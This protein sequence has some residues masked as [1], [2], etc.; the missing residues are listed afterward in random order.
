MKLREKPVFYGS[1]AVIYFIAYVFLI[2]ISSCVTQHNLE[3]MQDKNK[4]IKT[5]SE[6]Q[7]AD[8]RLKPN[9]EL[10]I[11]ISSLDEAAANVFTGT[12]T[13]QAYYM[14][15]ISPYG[16]SLISY[17]ID[18][19]GYLL[20]PYIGRLLVK[21]K[22]TAE[23]IESIKESLKNILSQ[24]VVSVKL[25]N[26][27]VSVLGEVRSPGHFA[28]AQDKLTI[29]DAISLAGDITVF[30]NREEVILT[31]NEDGKNIRINVNLNRSD[32]LSSEYYNLRPNDIV[33]VKPLRKRFWGMDQFP[34]AVIL[35][36][37]TTALLIYTVIK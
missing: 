22:T 8:Y 17:A 35:T 13:Q 20:L 24:P 14:S 25:V 31:R 36:T 21:D 7:I 2:L 5:F 1:G 16:A 6:A 26:R 15:S 3:Y 23:V 33:Y 19:D 12:S 4:T 18:R 27:Y 9:D 37:I 30:G 29:Y 34:Y 32:I 10:Y 28:Y 11:Q